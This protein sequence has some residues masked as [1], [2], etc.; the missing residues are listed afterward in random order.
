MNPF[1]R[2]A[3]LSVA[4]EG[5]MM[6]RAQRAGLAAAAGLV[7]LL[8][9]ASPMQA[10]LRGLAPAI[11]HPDFLSAGRVQYLRPNDR[12]IGVVEGGVAKAYPVMIVATHH[13]VD[14]K[15]P[16]GPIAVTW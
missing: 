2:A 15:S 3:Y 9:G 5:A 4:K 13:I 10:Q 7:L 12:V 11:D 8:V 1:P 16:K 14:D 6:K